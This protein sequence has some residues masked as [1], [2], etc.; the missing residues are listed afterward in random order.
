M[1]PGG[2]KNHVEG[3]SIAAAQ[4]GEAGKHL[5][6]LQPLRQRSRLN[7]SLELTRQ[8]HREYPILQFELWQQPGLVAGIALILLAF[9]GGGS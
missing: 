9:P 2:T 3:R 8:T 7:P 4:P 1:I 6:S 5:G